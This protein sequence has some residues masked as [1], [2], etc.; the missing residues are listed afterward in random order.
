[1]AKQPN[2]PDPFAE[3]P[4]DAAERQA[5]LTKVADYMRPRL[6]GLTHE[7]K[8]QLRVSWDALRDQET[9]EGFR[10]HA[11][12][13]LIALD[14]PDTVSPDES[15]DRRIGGF[16]NHGGD[17][18]NRSL[19]PDRNVLSELPPVDAPRPGAPPPI[20]IADLF[21]QN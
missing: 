12:A 5:M 18:S 2:D 4:L 10:T 1:M 21:R 14:T 20:D 8:A 7:Q 9:V 19:F 13:L 17:S 6:T 16:L 3:T 11:D 15:G